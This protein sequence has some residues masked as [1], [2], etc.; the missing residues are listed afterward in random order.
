MLTGGEVLQSVLVV[1][2]K[3]GVVLSKLQDLVVV[4]GE[5][6]DDGVGDRGDME[7]SVTGRSAHV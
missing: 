4:L 2:G 1:D 7:E 6:R 5:V 3:R